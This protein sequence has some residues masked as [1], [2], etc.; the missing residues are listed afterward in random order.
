MTDT[1]N[2]VTKEGGEAEATTATEQPQNEQP[3]QTAEAQ[4]EQSTESTTEPAPQ[5]GGADQ[6]TDSATQEPIKFD[7]PE[8]MNLPDSAIAA[9]TETAQSQGVTG[10]QAQALLDALAPTLT[11]ANASMIEETKNEWAQAVANDAELGGDKLDENMAIADKAVETFGDEGLKEL[12]N[13]GDLP[14]GKEPRLFRMLVRVGRA[15]SEAK[16]VNGGITGDGRQPVQG[17]VFADA[18]RA[19]SIMYPTK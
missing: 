11:D 13:D 7:V 4:P 19:S 16:S 10:E 5:D 17:D 2:E 18:T 1:T 8:T 9:L 14:L 15:V 12:L 3:T 6:S